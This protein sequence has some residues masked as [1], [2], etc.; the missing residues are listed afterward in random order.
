MNEYKII[1]KCKTQMKVEEVVEFLVKV[2]VTWAPKTWPTF[3][4]NGPQV[5]V[6]FSGLLPPL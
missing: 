1:V 6:V 3:N 2:R 5:E 4:G